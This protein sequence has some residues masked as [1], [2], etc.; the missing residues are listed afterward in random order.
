MTGR[1]RLREVKLTLPMAP[2]MEVVASQ[3]ASSLAAFIGMTPDRVDE[4]R[5]AV[6]ECCINAF[7]HSR[8]EDR[9]VDITFSLLGDG[10]PD[11]LEIAVHD[12]GVG[13]SVNDVEEP[14]IEAKLRGSRKRGWGLKIMQ[15][16]MDEVRILS[17]THGT[18]VV[19]CKTRGGR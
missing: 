4:V 12:D 5:L 10:E 3:A 8:S 7:E 15:G 1:S 19:M 17:S 2:D 6:V 9:K 14:R 18:T 16:L 11:T 13:F